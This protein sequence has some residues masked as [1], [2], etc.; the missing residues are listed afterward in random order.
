MLNF[1]RHK[2]PTIEDDICKSLFFS[3]KD[4]VPA[5]ALVLILKIRDME[6]S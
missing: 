1:A 3:Q 6:F 2:M 5:A 4:Q